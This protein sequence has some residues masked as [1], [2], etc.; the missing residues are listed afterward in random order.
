LKVEHL[1]AS[2]I[3]T[4]EQCPLKYYA[5]YD[6][7]LPE[8]PPHP[9]T[10]M[11]KA[12][13]W[14]MEVGVVRMMNGECVNF[15]ELVGP[16]CEKFKVAPENRELALDL[17]G[18]AIAWGGVRRVDS[19]MGCEVEFDIELE[20]GTKVKGFMDRVDSMAGGLDVL[21]WKTGKRPFDDGRLREE[22]QSRVYNVAARELYSCTGSVCLS[23]WALRH[24]VQ[25]VQMTEADAREDR[26]LLMKVADE[27]RSCEDPEGR[28]SG[29]CPWCPY[30]KDCPDR[31]NGVK[32]RFE[33][34]Y[35]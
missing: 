3:K 23:Y 10:L 32:R 18:N 19:T 9:L 11:G 24:R 26:K 17:V 1:S 25:R 4:Y 34:R 22:W 16:A 21:D 5:I 30:E 29:L 20:D 15:L 33:K 28:P 31:G 12:V 7:K 2:R 35:G 14:V 8:P 6:L 27:I 13:H